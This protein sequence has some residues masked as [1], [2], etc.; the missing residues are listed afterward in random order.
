MDS[1]LHIGEVAR[2]LG[3]TPKTLRHYEKIGLIE[4]SRLDNAYR[5]YTP[6]EVERLQ[7]IRQMQSLGLS[8][9][10]IG[11]ILDD[12]EN[13]QLWNAVLESVLSDIQSEIDALEARK[14]RIAGLLMG[15]ASPEPEPVPGVTQPHMA[16]NMAGSRAA[17]LISR[18]QQAQAPEALR[19][20]L[21]DLVR[22]AD[23]AR[24][25]QLFAAL[26]GQSAGR[27]AELEWSSDPTTWYSWS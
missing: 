15:D 6:D 25:A 18:F 11:M 22:D 17:A 13:E 27:P 10:Q 23:L 16:L 14:E 21:V 7:R 26:A 8:L 12:A 5:V 1:K 9:R 24:R 3:V 2:L 19:A 4:P 20:L